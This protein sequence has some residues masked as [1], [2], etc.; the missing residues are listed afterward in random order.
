MTITATDFFDV[1]IVMARRAH[2][3]NEQLRY[4]VTQEAARIMAEQGIQDFLLAKRKAAER[5]GITDA[6]VLPKNSEIEN[7]LIARQRLFHSHHHDD[8]ILQLRRSALRL[9][10][11]LQEFQ[12]RL[13]GSV[14]TGSAS[15]HSEINV[16]VFVDHAERI[17][18][19][20]DERGITH[21]H[22]EKK[23]RYESDRYISYPSFKFIAGD[24]AIEVV[25]LPVDGIR[26]SPLSPVDG[27]PMQRATIA[28]VESL[29]QA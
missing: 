29:V 15:A 28:D 16:H 3:R 4:A 9:M 5:I 2:T 22:A 10:R 12:P 26:Q 19:T 24:H 14:L 6:A 7:A 23:L 27:K 17:S 25:A 13:V 20:L 21:Q 18:V 11:L 1:E 8:A